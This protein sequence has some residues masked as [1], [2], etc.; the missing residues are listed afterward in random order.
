MFTFQVGT[1]TISQ[2]Q[3]KGQDHRQQLSDSP[4]EPDIDSE[5]LR[6]DV[7]SPAR[8]LYNPRSTEV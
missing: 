1:Q 6:K 4:A 5:Q 8:A 2:V 7:Q 3:H